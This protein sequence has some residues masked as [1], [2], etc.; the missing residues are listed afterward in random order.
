MMQKD[1]YGGLVAVSEVN[2]HCIVSESLTR[3]RGRG[4][5]LEIKDVAVININTRRRIGIEAE[6]H[7]TEI[8][9]ASANNWQRHCQF[10]SVR[11]Q[12]NKIGD[13]LTRRS[14]GSSLENWLALRNKAATSR[15]RW[16]LSWWYVSIK[17]KIQRW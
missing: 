11:A 12:A 1:L 4:N 10:V 16:W 5:I 14:R 15:L 13:P 17:S 7:T 8:E 9:K 3:R 6:V 2:N